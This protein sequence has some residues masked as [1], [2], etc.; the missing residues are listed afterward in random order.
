VIQSSSTTSILPGT[1]M[2]LMLMTLFGFIALSILVISLAFKMYEKHH[3][4][5]LTTF[6]NLKSNDPFCFI[7]YIY[8][9]IFGNI[10]RKAKQI[11]FIIAGSF[12]V[13][14]GILLLVI[15]SILTINSLTSFN[16]C[17]QKNDHAYKSQNV[18]LKL[19][20][21]T[22]CFSDTKYEVSGVSTKPSD[23]PDLGKSSAILFCFR[24]DHYR[25]FV[26]G[27]DVLGIVGGI[28]GGTCLILGFAIYTILMIELFLGTWLCETKL[29]PKFFSVF[30]ID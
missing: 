4:R 18:E 30:K 5:K 17:S 8:F 15:F 19:N 2:T 20:L 13:F 12:F 24:G 29:A 6:S 28:V 14:M 11:Q 27:N 9:K 16:C 25:L 7:F 10:G 26:R 21:P 1:Y 23:L 3:K 22:A